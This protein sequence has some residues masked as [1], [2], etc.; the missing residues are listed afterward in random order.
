LRR[1]RRETGGVQEKTYIFEGWNGPYSGSGESVPKIE[2][3]E[4]PFLNNPLAQGL[5]KASSGIHNGMEADVA[6]DL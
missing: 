1:D 6:I 4:A 5:S 3:V 2:Q